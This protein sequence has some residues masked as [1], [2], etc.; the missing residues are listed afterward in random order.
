M[1]RTAVT[2]A[3]P[4]ASVVSETRSLPY[5]GR[6]TVDGAPNTSGGSSAQPAYA[7]TSSTALATG[8]PSSSVTRYVASTVGRTISSCSG[9][10][11]SNASDTKDTRWVVTPPVAVAGDADTWTRRS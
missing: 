5:H 3:E 10:R 7:V 8:F 2:G 9:P 1:P 6:H 11:T 4:D